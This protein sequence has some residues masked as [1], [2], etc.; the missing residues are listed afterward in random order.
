MAEVV[1]DW[2]RGYL[3]ATGGS[4]RPPTPPGAGPGGVED[5]IR[6]VAAARGFAD[7][8]LLVATAR[9]ESSLDPSAVGDQG[10]SYGV[11]QEHSRGR[12]AGIPVESRRDVAAATERA[13]A[14]F[15]AIR[16][17]SPTADRGTWA[18]LAQ[19]P[20]DPGDY[21]RSVNALLTQGRSATPAARA[22]GVTQDAQP[23]ADA[24]AWYRAYT[25]AGGAPSAPGAA[26]RG[27]EEVWPV[28]GHRWGQV[29]NPFGGR[30]SRSAGATVPLPSSNVGADLTAS[31]G[32]P[33]VA[34]TT[35][36]VVQTFD[37]PNETD[38]NLNSGW[39]G[40]VLLQGDNGY[41][42]RLSHQQPGL[43][44]RPGQRVEAGQPLGR[45][46]VSGNTTGPHL[47]AEKFDRPGHFV[48]IT[49]GAAARPPAA[50][51][52]GNDAPEWFRAYASAGGRN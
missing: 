31:Y 11:F 46:G 27:G 10:Q 39:G 24:P 23:G 36:T 19:R 14:E 40:M 33:V 12:G 5:T 41:F 34:P 28:A 26:T 52:A 9:Q 43:L 20:A 1:P 50:P 32:D 15:Q 18:A 35:G 21:A 17:R 4:P 37:A 44:V 16:Q 42:Y 49:A 48:D 38:R 3:A 22:P 47:D 29:N 30:Q 2:L 25:A 51:R 7:P 6:R 45:V 8:D 13:I